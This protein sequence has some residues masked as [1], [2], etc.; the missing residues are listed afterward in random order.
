MWKALLKV[1][2]QGDET[3]AQGYSTLGNEQYKFDRSE[4]IVIV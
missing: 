2:N 4:F 1:P 3:A